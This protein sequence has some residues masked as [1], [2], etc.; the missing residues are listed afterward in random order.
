MCTCGIVQEKI[1]RS[2]VL[3]GLLIVPFSKVEI[4]IES[5]K[6]IFRVIKGH[7]W[8]RPGENV[9][10]CPDFKGFGFCAI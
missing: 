9:Q 2:D 1:F 8:N 4:Q 3:R 10:R 5:K 6:E 7:N